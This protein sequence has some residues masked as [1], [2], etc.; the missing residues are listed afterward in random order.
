VTVWA[1][2]IA[3][4]Q[5]LASR[6]LGRSRLTTLA[7]A[8]D[9]RALAALLSDAYGDAMLC[10]TPDSASLERSARQVAGA[11]LA[12]IARWSGA[13]AALLAPLF[14]EDDRRN[15]AAIARGIV[16]GAPIEHRTS[17]LIPTV[18]LPTS[19]LEELA[20][21]ADLSHVASL[22]TAWQN[23]YAAP[24]LEEATR[25]HPNLFLV[26][27]ALDRAY[28]ARAVK[29]ARRTGRALLSHVRLQID[30]QNAW[31]A[32][33]L[34]D[35]AEEHTDAALYVDGGLRL[36]R[37]FFLTLARAR[38]SNE[39]RSRIARELRGTA[40]A[41]VIADTEHASPEDALLA[42]SLRR[43]L[44]NARQHPLD[45][46]VILRYTL[47]LRAEVRD[48]A[49]IAWGIALDRPREQLAAALV[50]P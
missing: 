2:V 20:R 48:V 45:V 25:E 17:S 33:A 31:T 15:L 12:I 40:V 6:L 49:R 42:E 4:V 39:A 21:Q 9:L 14:E 41:R 10:E 11:R 35:H 7:T 18:S 30:T 23:P 16:A 27:L 29:T 34:S 47:R 13:R 8:H 24:L 38:D 43:S 36:S 44:A 46:G 26:L 32:L 50:S 1:D 3:R 28:V 5:G 37:G 19:A 22:L